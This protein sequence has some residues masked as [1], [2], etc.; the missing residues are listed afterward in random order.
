MSRQTIQ[1]DDEVLAYVRDVSLRET[2]LQ[3]ELREV[4]ADRERS[5]MQI[6]AEQGQFMTLLVELTGVDRALEIGT[7]TGYSAMSIVRGM[8]EGGEL[9]ACDVDAETTA[10]ARDFW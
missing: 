8:R 6:S 4:T 2:D 9:I 10:V 7:Y 1:L 3:R 5:Q